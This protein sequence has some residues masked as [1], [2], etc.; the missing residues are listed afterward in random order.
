MKCPYCDCNHVSI[1][2]ESVS[3]MSV[4]LTRDGDLTDDDIIDSEHRGYF[5]GCCSTEVSED[6]A[7][8]LLK[9]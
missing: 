4:Y 8:K 5:T 3:Y 6:E 7:I 9:D 1:M 2:R